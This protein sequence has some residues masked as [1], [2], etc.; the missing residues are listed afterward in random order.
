[1]KRYGPPD[2]ERRAV[3]LG[4]DMKTTGAKT[5]EEETFL[6]TVTINILKLSGL[7]TTLHPSG[8]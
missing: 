4:S 8:R 7:S 3:F 1:M 2:V 5:G 6:T